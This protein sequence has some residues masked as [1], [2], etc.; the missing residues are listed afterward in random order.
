MRLMRW[1]CALLLLWLPNGTHADPPTLEAR[2]AA[3]ER[4]PEA[5]IAAEPT[6]QARRALEREA[7][8]RG[9][10][11]DAAAERAR[12]I[13][14]AAVI[15]SE[16]IVARA[17]AQASLREAEAERDEALRRKQVAEAALENAR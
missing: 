1:L 15:L 11:N 5:S 7:E 6:R 2:L 10:G 8:L 14:D 16:R 9:A 4:A 13:A 17:R 12:R 3:V